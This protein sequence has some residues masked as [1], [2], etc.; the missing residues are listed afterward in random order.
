MI[1]SYKNT[2]QQKKLKNATEFSDRSWLSVVEPTEKEIEKISKQLNLPIDILQDSLDRFELPRIEVEGENIVVILRSIVEEK[3]TYKTYPFTIILNKKLLTTVSPVKNTLI[4]D[5]ANQ[6]IN[7]YTTQQSNFLI[8]L[9]LRLIHY[10]QKHIVV[11]N[12]KVQ[13]EKAQIEDIDKSDVYSLVETEEILNN[14]IASLTPTIHTI[15]KLLQYN[16]IH[17]YQEDKDLIDDVLVDGQQVL[18]LAITNLKTVKNVRDAYTTVMSIQLNQTMKLLTY[19]TALFTIPML[20][21]SIYGMNISLPFADWPHAFLAISG[22]ALALV[23]IAAFIFI[24]F[25]K[26]L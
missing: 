21:S 20:I 3:G 7:F 12:R 19:I 2:I 17:L 9:C 8:N 5:F 1:K 23:F 24:S 14:I 4:D 25:R 6:K 15:K 26:K 10:Y 16:Y 13:K 18:E 22:L 11:L